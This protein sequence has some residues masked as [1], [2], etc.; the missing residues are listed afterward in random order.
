LKE[1]KK[2][3]KHAERAIELAKVSGEDYAETEALLAR[4]NKL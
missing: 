3:K 4:I 2:A 1:K